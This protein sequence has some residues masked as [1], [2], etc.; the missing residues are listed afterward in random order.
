MEGLVGLA[1]FVLT[2]CVIL[3]LVAAKRSG[4]QQ[5]TD[6]YAYDQRQPFLSAAERSFYG[7]LSDAVAS[8]GAVMAK[9]RIADVITPRKSADRAEWQKAFNRI[10]AKHFDFVL[11][12]PSTL[13]P[14]VVI[15]LDDD[16]HR[17]KS[18]R[19]RDEVKDSV[20]RSA[21]LPLVRVRAKAAYVVE[22]IRS[23]L[24]EYLP[25]VGFAPAAAPSQL[26]Q[27]LEPTC[28]KCESGM[29]LR[30]VA[31]GSNAGK[32]FWGCSRFPS[33]R[34]TLP[35]ESNLVG[36]SPLESPQ[37]ITTE[38]APVRASSTPSAR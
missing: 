36:K 31:K 14:L 9:V 18:A 22:D 26:A 33:C 25:R 24:L 11:C 23:E 10:S 5:P 13:E 4:R 32:R 16:S 28:P 27:P 29:T 8:D 17:G 21:R 34:G 38:T 30:T 6:E 35:F 20:A 15:E 37:A 19:A 7:V 3:V 1:A 2:A 12:A